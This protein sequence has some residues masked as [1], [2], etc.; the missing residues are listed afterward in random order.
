MKR[1]DK[2]YD[3]GN[4]VGKGMVRR[5]WVLHG[6]RSHGPGHGAFLATICKVTEKTVTYY[7]NDPQTPIRMD[8]GG[9]LFVEVSQRDI[10]RVSAA[11]RIREDHI[12]AAKEVADDH[13]HNECEKILEE[14]DA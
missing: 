8:K 5:G 1:P 7:T 11:W 6:F 4:A 14:E 12:A 10:D 3:W 9:V 13:Y 2:N